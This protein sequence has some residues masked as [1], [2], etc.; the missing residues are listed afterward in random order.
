MHHVPEATLSEFENLQLADWIDAFKVIHS[1]DECTPGCNESKSQQQIR[2]VQNAFLQKSVKSVETEG[3]TWLRFSCVCILLWCCSWS[4]ISLTIG[5]SLLRSIWLKLGDV[6]ARRDMHAWSCPGW[7]GTQPDKCSHEKTADNLNPWCL[8]F[9]V[10]TLNSWLQLAC[11]I[12]ECR[13]WVQ[14]HW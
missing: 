10:S 2:P 12:E 14:R 1:T 4:R 6:A 7:R 9:S 11:W 3:V 8:T 13:S 5:A